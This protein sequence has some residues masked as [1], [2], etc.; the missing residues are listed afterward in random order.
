MGSNAGNLQQGG[1]GWHA[2]PTRKRAKNALAGALEGTAIARRGFEE[3]DSY[4]KPQYDFGQERLSGFKDWLSNPN[5]V[6]DDPSYKWRLG[7]GTEALENS[8]AARGGLLSGNTGKAL[9]DYGQN[10]ASQEYGAQF[11]RWME[12]LGLGQNATSARSSIAQNK[13]KTV[14]AMHAGAWQQFFN[15][16]LAAIG[17]GRAAA[18]QLNSMI[19]SWVPSGGGAG[20]GGGGG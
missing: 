10:A 3:A 20:G 16:E 14:G 1:A 13:G 17:E 2:T 4:W 19:K 18:G 6:T 8:A 15:N 5:A 12:Q 9:Q 7:Q 11:G